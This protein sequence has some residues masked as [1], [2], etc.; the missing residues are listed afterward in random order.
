MN[1]LSFCLLGSLYLAFISAGQLW[2]MKYSWLLVL[3]FSTL[4][5]L[6]YSLLACK[7]SAKKS[8]ESLMGVSLLERKFFLLLLLKILSFSLI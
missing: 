2:S 7:A 6:S 4:N 8:A 1:S 3:Y 5:V